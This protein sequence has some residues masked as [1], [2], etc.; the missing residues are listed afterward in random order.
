[1]KAIRAAVI[2]LLVTAASSLNLQNDSD[3]TTTAL[4]QRYNE[5][6]SEIEANNLS[7]VALRKKGFPDGDTSWTDRIKGADD[8]INLFYKRLAADST[9][10][11]DV[12]ILIIGDREIMIIT[13]PNGSKITTSYPKSLLK[14]PSLNI[15]SE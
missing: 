9:I 1:M 4:T 5:L 6:K 7:I 10:G 2:L 11:P 8:W 13:F 12:R 14:T 3:L 15:F